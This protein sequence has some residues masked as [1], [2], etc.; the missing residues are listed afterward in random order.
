MHARRRYSLPWTKA[1]SELLVL[2]LG[3]F[4]P[5]LEVLLAGALEL[6]VLILQQVLHDVLVHRVCEVD[7]FIALLQQLLSKWTGF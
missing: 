7:D 1:Y 3:V 4:V 2:F 6:Q 5:Q